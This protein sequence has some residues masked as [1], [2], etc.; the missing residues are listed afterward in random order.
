MIISAP[1]KQATVIINARADLTFPTRAM[2]LD[3]VKRWSRYTLT[4]H[5]I[6]STSSDGSVDVRVYDIDSDKKAFIDAYI[7][8]T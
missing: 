7:E 3:F 8:T 2:A 5:S 4:G 6:A 1:D